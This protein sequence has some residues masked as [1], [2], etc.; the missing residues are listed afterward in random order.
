MGSHS[1]RGMTL[2]LSTLMREMEDRPPFRALTRMR[3]GYRGEAPAHSGWSLLQAHGSS[4]EALGP[5][6][7]GFSEL[8]G[9]QKVHMTRVLTLQSTQQGLDG[10]LN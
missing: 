10:T 3:D 7:C 4:P 1:P 8:S 5:D 6:A 2:G 9:F